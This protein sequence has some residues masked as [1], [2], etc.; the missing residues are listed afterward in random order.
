MYRIIL[1][2]I[3]AM[4]LPVSVGFSA[5]VT[6]TPMTLAVLLSSDSNFV[7]RD[8]EGYTVVIGQVVNNDPLTSITNVMVNVDFY[9][10]TGINLLESNVGRT[11]LDVIPPMGSSPFMIKSQSPNPEIMLTNSN[12]VGFD[13]SSS[14]LNQLAVQASNILY[15]DGLL[16]FSG[17]LSNGAAPTSDAK[18]HVA[19][20]DKFDPPRLVGIHTILLEDIFANENVSFEFNQPINSHAVGLYLFSESD[21]FYSD[22]VN[23]KIP[24]TSLVKQVVIG[25]VAITDSWGTPLSEV[26][27]GSTANIVSESWIKYLTHPDLPV[28]EYTYFVQIK[29]FG[30]QPFVEF[31]GKYDGVYTGT[32]L[33]RPAVEWVPNSAGEFFVET[34]VWNRDNVPIAVQGPLV[35]ISV[36]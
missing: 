6:D 10:T 12:L 28:T 22:F 35:L 27:I 2:V 15:V 23:V 24:R 34:F 19:L 1:V 7:Y 20:Y 29:R 3:S 25:N 18:I 21:T 9:S 33:H 26:P 14:K 5:E 8:D 32:E 4:I 31:V 16:S 36:K 30:E 17:V 11:V 13:S